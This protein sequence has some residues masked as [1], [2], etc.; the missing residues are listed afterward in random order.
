[1]ATPTVT[2]LPN[3]LSTDVDSGPFADFAEPRWNRYHVWFDDFDNYTAASWV[4]TETLAGATQGVTSG[5]GGI[6]ALVNS[7][8]DDDLN[9]IQWAGG[10]GAVTPSF[11]FD[12]TKDMF[13]ATR[14]KVDD[15]T[16]SDVLIGLAIADTTPIASLPANGIF[17][18]KSDD[19]ASLIVSLRASGT[20]TSLTVGTLSN[21]TYVDVAFVYNSTLGRWQVF[22]NNA[23]VA[24]TTT[25]TNAPS[26]ALAPTITLQNGSAA[27]RTLSVDWLFVAKQR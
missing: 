27:A 18:L 21:D 1:M 12:S 25:L 11:T 22:L 15:A 14:F 2:R 3:G 7:A 10:A 19:A 16:Q 24:T 6:L 20:S 4:V 9:S 17:F 26:A 8:A 23:L 13:I 5:D